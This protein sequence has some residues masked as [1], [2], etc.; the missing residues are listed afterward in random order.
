MGKIKYKFV[1]KITTLASSIGIRRQ[2]ILFPPENDAFVRNK[3]EG[4]NS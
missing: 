2:K 1:H 4:M 3:S